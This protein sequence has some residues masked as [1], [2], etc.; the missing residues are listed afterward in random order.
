M[1]VYFMVHWFVCL[2]VCLSVWMTS[3]AFLMFERDSAID[4]HF[5][6]K[7]VGLS[8]LCTHKHMHVH[9]CVFTYGHLSMSVSLDSQVL[10]DVLHVRQCGLHLAK[11]PQVSQLATSI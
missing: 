4:Y 6:P 9:E 7:G 3:D 10:L 1:F 8:T 5:N 2:S 11:F